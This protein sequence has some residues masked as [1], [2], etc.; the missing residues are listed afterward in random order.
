[1]KLPALLILALSCVPLSSALA[2]SPPADGGLLITRVNSDQWKIRLIAGASERR[3]SGIVE[4][5]MPI[6][7]LSSTGSDRN[8]G[9]KLLT[10][11]SLGAIL[12]VGPGGVDGATFTAPADA[13]LCLRDAGSSNVRMYLGN[14]L[15]DAVPVTAPV[16]LG[17]VDACGDALAPVL[18][19]SSGRKYHPGHYTIVVNG[20]DAQAFMSSSL[21]PGMM[22]I[23]RRY[24]WRSL[25]PTQGVYDFSVMKSDLAWA[26]AHGTHFVVVIEY[27][28]TDGTKAGP[29]YLDSLEIRNQSGGYTLEMWSPTVVTRYNAL[30]KAL[31]VQFDSLANFDGL[32]NQE[33]ALSVDS[34]TLKALGY[35]PELYRDALIS[36]LSSAT[37]S[38]PTSRVFWYMNFLQGNQ[39]YI[40]TIAS[41]VAPLGVAMGGPDDWPDSQSLESKAYPYYSQFAG[42]MPLFIQVEGVNYAEPHMTKGY[43][44]KDWTML[45]LYEFAL[46]NLHVNYMFWMR[47]PSPANAAAYDWSDALPVIAA[48]PTLN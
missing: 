10:P 26:A 20:V 19:G 38:L 36:M 11:N 29:A 32:G 41:A 21:Q 34:G 16:A 44:T 23:V 42:K 25:E 2:Q 35:T 13:K 33:T 17:S 4:S 18:A 40:G 14:S 43:S 22:G 47:I 12:S 5:N 1:M 31:G 15:A 45:E 46:T 8:D 3:F 24:T 7:G 39:A 27:K 37:V 48:H 28:T 9:V 30:V 6:A